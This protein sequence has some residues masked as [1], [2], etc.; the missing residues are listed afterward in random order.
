MTTAYVV[1]FERKRN[2]S[3]L[4]VHSGDRGRPAGA[5]QEKTG[6]PAGDSEGLRTGQ[7]PLWARLRRR[8]ATPRFSPPLLTRPRPPRGGCALA[9]AA[10]V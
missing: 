9:F 3:D 4:P 8:G 10:V 6:A 1:V 7:T 5:L 2:E